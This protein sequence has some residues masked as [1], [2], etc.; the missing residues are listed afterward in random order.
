M[1]RILIIDDDEIFCQSLSQVLRHAGHEVVTALDGAIALGLYR[2]EPADLVITDLIMP[3]KEG[4]ETIMELRRMKSDLKIIAVSGGGWV[5]ASEYLTMAQRL[6]A[7]RT[8]AKPFTTRDILE[9]VSGP[10]HQESFVTQ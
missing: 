5:G 4:L 2:Q 10:L 7:A 8:L 6:G 9:T 3:G 1:S